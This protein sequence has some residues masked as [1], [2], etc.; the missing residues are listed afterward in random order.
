M[1]SWQ[2]PALRLL[3][4][5]EQV[6]FS[7]SYYDCFQSQQGALGN[8]CMTGLA[9]V[10]IGRAWHCDVCI[11]QEFTSVFCD[12]CIDQ[13]FTS[14]FWRFRKTVEK[15][16]SCMLCPSCQLQLMSAIIGGAW[17]HPPHCSSCR[18]SLGAWS[19]R[20][21]SRLIQWRGCSFAWLAGERPPPVFLIVRPSMPMHPC[22]FGLQQD[23][24][25]NVSLHV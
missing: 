24:H 1:F 22:M 25:A 17:S 6:C 2:V 11:D 14:V 9:W 18:P 21:E 16:L 15:L 3:H 20:A 5:F 7:N 13:E 23:I 8:R 10:Q 19:S 4:V 12:V